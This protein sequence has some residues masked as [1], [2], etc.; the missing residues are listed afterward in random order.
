M[1]REFVCKAL[2]LIRDL[3]SK[4]VKRARKTTNSLLFSL[5]SGNLREKN[6]QTIA[7]PGLESALCHP[8]PSPAGPSASLDFAKMTNARVKPAHDRLDQIDRELLY[9]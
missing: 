7:V 4:I 1:Y 3:I 6:G 5:L 2:K 9:K 8:P